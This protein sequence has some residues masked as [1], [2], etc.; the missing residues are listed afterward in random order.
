MLSSSGHFKS[1]N[2]RKVFYFR[3][4]GIGY[5]RTLHQRILKLKNGNYLSIKIKLLLILNQKSHNLLDKIS[6]RRIVLN[7]V[8]SFSSQILCIKNFYWTKGIKKKK[9]LLILYIYG[10]NIKEKIDKKKTKPYK[11][12]KKPYKRKLLWSIDSGA[13]KLAISLSSYLSTNH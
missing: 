6:N 9:M 3:I 10:I 11:E 7:I 12:T 4:K 2:F 8:K 5:I 1:K 13:I